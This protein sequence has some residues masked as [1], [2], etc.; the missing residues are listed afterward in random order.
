MP[1]LEFDKKEILDFI[2][3]RIDDNK[4]AEYISFIGTDLERIDDKIVVE[5]FPNR[6]DMLS[7][8]GFAR[9][10]SSFIGIKKGLKRYSVNK[11]D[12]KV[13]IDKSVKDVRP[14]TVC[15]VVKGI[16]FDDKKIES[17][18]Q[19]QEKLHVTLCRNRKKAAIGVYPLEKIRFPIRYIGEDPKKIR[20]VP[21]DSNKEMNGLDILKKH[22]TGIEYGHLLK[23]KKRFPIFIDSNDN[24]L[25]MPP[26]INSETVGK[27]TDNTRDVFVEC[28]G[29]DIDFLNSVLNIIVTTLSDMGGK[30]YEVDIVDNKRYK[31]PNLREKKMNIDINYVNKILGLKLNKND[32]KNLVSKMGYGYD[33]ST[34]SAYIP[35]YRVDILHPIDVVEDIAIAYGYNN[36]KGEIPEIATIS[37]VDDFNVFKDKIAEI[38]VGLG[39]NEATTYHLTN[40]EIQNK[41]MNTKNDIIKLENALTSEYNVLR[42]WLLPNILDVLE[43]NKTREY[44]HNIFEIG[45]VFNKEKNNIKE[46][47]KLSIVVSDKNVTFTNIKQIFDY[48][49]MILGFDY[50][51]NEINHD[52][53]IPGRVGDIIVNGKNIGIIG[54]IHPSVLD[55]FG[56]DFPV[57][58]LEIDLDGLYGLLK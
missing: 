22:K 21:L 41:R 46:K 27:V 53:F 47:T 8:Q 42:Y 43:K 38:I 19:M 30:I 49:S 2:G 35:C 4:L 7:E 54:E 13:Y 24:I 51:I 33:N 45:V 1:T 20:F 34:N 26:I 40:D 12:Y 37:S 17:I 5:I 23:G 29:F 57:S 58:C 52:S 39:F 25:S 16:R 31:T 10:L 50:D 48:I 6:P 32:L 3:K 56:L 55:N 18:I 9:A 28:S 44:P 11:S 15:A 36:F 14:Y